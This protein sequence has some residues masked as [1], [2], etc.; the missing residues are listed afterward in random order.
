MDPVAQD[1]QAV[2]RFVIRSLERMG[3]KY[4][5]GGSIASSMHGPGRFTR[6]ADITVE[7][8]AGREAEFVTA[9]DADDFYVSEDAVRAAIRDRSTFN[10]L[11]PATGY[12]ID[13][14][15]RKDEP[16]E[17][18][19]FARRGPHPMPDAP[20][21]LVQILS[22]EDIILF[23]LRWYVIGGGI[24]DR[25]LTDI[26]GVMRTQGDQLDAAYLDHWAAEL[27]VAALLAELR[28]QV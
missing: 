10:I 22:A 16:F 11:H 3:L 23:K 13:F 7:P 2:L 8:F 24:S 4:A 18:S 19:A 17:R 26:L 15:V 6:D 21:E 5:I 28:K 14:F 27:G 12:K 9:F 1:Y 20:D 25:Q